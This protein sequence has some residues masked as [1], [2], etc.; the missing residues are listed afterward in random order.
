MLLLPFLS[1]LHDDSQG[2]SGNLKSLAIMFGI[3]GDIATV[4]SE[5]D[6][7]STCSLE[8]CL[9][10]LQKDGEPLFC[11]PFEAIRVSPLVVLSNKYST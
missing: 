1:S 2:S 3:L 7:S 4:Y 6:N 8:A 10:T 5:T 11:F 9:A